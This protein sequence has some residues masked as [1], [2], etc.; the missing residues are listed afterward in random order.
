VTDLFKPQWPL[1]AFDVHKFGAYGV[2]R[3][4]PDEGACG[5]QPHPCQHWGVDLSAPGGTPVYAPHNGWVLY[6]G[7]AV[8]P[9]S[10]Y[11]P[12]VMLIAHADLHTSLT[13]RLWDYVTGPLKNIADFPEGAVSVRYSL[14]AHLAHASTPAPVNLVGDIWDAT[15][16]KPNPDHWRPVKGDSRSIIMMT[17]AEGV[18]PSRQVYAGQQ[19]GTVDADK[20]HVHWELRTAPLKPSRAG[21]FRIDPIETFRQQYGLELP[22]GVKM[23]AKGGGAGWLLLLALLAFSD[24]RKRR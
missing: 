20:Q 4:S 15:K 9:F 18:T 16:A 11:G 3:N 7:A 8:Q 5:T 19:I 21:N 6:N 17:D 1:R 23:P 12:R 22:S 10:G 14:I 24:R 2:T 13:S